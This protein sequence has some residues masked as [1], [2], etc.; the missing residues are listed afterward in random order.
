VLLTQLAVGYEFLVTYP[1]SY[2]A[3]AFEFSRV[4][5]HHWSVNF[6]FVPE[7][8]FVSA[9]F[10]GVLLACHLV[11]LLALAHTRWH[12]HGGGFFPAFVLDFFNRR[13]VERAREGPGLD[14]RP[15]ARRARA[16]RG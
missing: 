4:F 2:V 1:G 14:L 8:L 15:V 5:V 12:R 11:A 10:A 6:K 16:V 3:K 9:S 13:E 7:P